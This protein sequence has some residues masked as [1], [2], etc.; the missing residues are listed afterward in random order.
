MGENPLSPDQGLYLVIVY[1]VVMPFA[2]VS[3][4]QGSG[5]SLGHRKPGCPGMTTV[6][7]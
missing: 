4:R 5:I 2:H 7:Y 3:G 1:I 6:C